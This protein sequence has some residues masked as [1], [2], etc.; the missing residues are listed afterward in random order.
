MKHKRHQIINAIHSIFLF[1]LFINIYI[2]KLY[3][4]EYFGLGNSLYSIE[5]STL[6]CNCS[7]YEI[8]PS[9]NFDGIAICT[10]G[11]LFGD[12][13]TGLYE[14]DPNTGSYTFIMPSIN[15]PA[16]PDGLVCAGNGIFYSISNLG[17]GF[18]YEINSNNGLITN[19]GEIGYKL[20]GE[21]TFLMA[22]YI[23]VRLFRLQTK[24][25]MV[26]YY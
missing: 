2:S 6:T 18:L 14:I 26:L 5:L 17:N 8:G 16:N 22:T 24:S 1:V 11:T 23:L 21:L 4:Q 19:I 20:Y 15:G 9:S 25:C 3:S 10:D 12:A 7:Y 13:D